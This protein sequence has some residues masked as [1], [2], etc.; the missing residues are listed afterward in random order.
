MEIRLS[1]HSTYRTQYHIV[2]ITKYRRKI[3]KL[4]LAR[5]LT[6]IF[7]RELRSMPGVEI[8]EH[9]IQVDHVHLLLI[10]PPKYSVSDIVG[11]LKGKSSSE[12][13]ARY[14]WLRKVYWKENILWSPGYFV[15]TVGI[16]EETVI[17]YV[18][19]QQEQDSGQ[20]R[21]EL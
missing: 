17:R 5:H 19:F 4:G 13:R 15:S 20:L 16:D 11:R 21:M 7:N 1:G 14:T 3:L 12:L 8:V 18:K 6:L 9:N 2:W 10:I